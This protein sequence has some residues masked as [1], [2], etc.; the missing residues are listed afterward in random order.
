VL[1]NGECFG[2]TVESEKTRLDAIAAQSTFDPNKYN[3]A[4]RGDL[5]CTVSTTVDTFALDTAVSSTSSSDGNVLVVDIGFTDSNQ[6]KAQKL[7]G[8]SDTTTFLAVASSA[9][10]D[11]NG[12]N[13]DVLDHL[14]VSCPDPCFG[15]CTCDLEVMAVTAGGDFT[16]DGTRPQLDSFNVNMDAAGL[17]TM[18][19]TE[20]VDVDSIYAGQFSLQWKINDA[21]ESVALTGSSVAAK[22]DLCYNPACSSTQDVLGETKCG[23]AHG[24]KWDSTAGVC[25]NTHC[26]L[27][28]D[29][30]PTASVLNAIKLKRGLAIT[31]ET[32]YMAI[33]NTPNAAI[34][35]MA[36]LPADAIATGAAQIAK[37]FEDDETDPTL[38][39]YVLDM[40]NFKLTLSFSEVVDA[41]SVTE[42]EIVLEGADANEP[43]VKLSGSTSKSTTDGEEIDIIITLGD[44]NK[45]KKIKTLATSPGSTFLTFNDE[46]VVDAATVPNKVEAVSRMPC[47][48]LNYKPDTVS[49]VIENFD[50]NMATGVLTLSF[51]ETVLRDRIQVNELRIQ[52]SATAPGQTRPLL[53]LADVQ[54]D[55]SHIITVTLDDADLN[56]IKRLDQTCTVDGGDCF[57]VSTI[58]AAK[59]M[60]DVNQVDTVVLAVSSSGYAE[61]TIDPQFLSFDLD[62]HNGLLTIVFD[63]TVDAAEL[64]VDAIELHTDKT[65]P[66]VQSVTLTKLSALAPGGSA[67][68]SADS[69]TIIITLGDDD[70]DELKKDTSLAVATASSVFLTATDET[71]K[72]MN[73]QSLVGV[74]NTPCRTGGFT[75]DLVRPTLEGFEMD[76]N[77]R[78]ITLTFSETMKATDLVA[79]EFVLQNAAQ[80]S[81]DNS[82]RMIASGVK[83][84][85]D[86]PVL[87]FV[88]SE[89]DA[90]FL[91]IKT[92]LCTHATTV[93]SVTT[94]DCY[95]RLTENAAKDMDGNK[96]FAKLD[97]AAIPLLSN[98]FVAD[99]QSPVL[100]G[101]DWEMPT[102][103]PPIKLTLTFS[104]T[105]LLSS[106]SVNFIFIRDGQGT[107]VQ[108]STA[109]ASQQ[110]LNPRILELTVHV[111]DLASV[112]EA[113]GVGS[114]PALTWLSIA[115]GAITD[116]ANKPVQ[117][118]FAS[119]PLQVNDG[120]HSVDVT[121]PKVTKF[122]LDLDTGYLTVYY[123]DASSIDA[124][125][126]DPSKFTITS[127]RTN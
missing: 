7:I 104:E 126:V 114:T 122:D 123:E 10:Q 4:F 115:P 98:G 93:N 76:M 101:F 105:V 68:S 44:M 25:G 99:N 102:G 16:Q 46:L 39:S 8:V 70:L 34:K 48:T 81:G 65:Q 71:I 72:D 79:T 106:L 124:S 33:S 3:D 60:T 37:S 32:S 45:I 100:Q 6:L 95:I 82:L 89:V 51:S 74:A 85:T 14:T 47:P 77:S 87:S 86:G 75:P 50:L 67:S 5:T 57:L 26:G 127:E 17:I 78:T 27:V 53:A 52:N 80:S 21:T 49:P 69:T 92:G 54:A 84:Q 110:P 36:G 90:D 22:E 42:T 29:F 107:A 58:N 111:D 120:G 15:T 35:D 66:N 125:T 12:N 24:C 61:D 108:L 119:N 59:D 2:A 55:D 13:V 117:E 18:T 118:I 20:T 43:T 113:G 40:D 112:R 1:E 88:F 38:I 23:Q 94:T 9:V 64:N 116:H 62:M 121:P 11:M 91:K 63:E 30:T 31:K 109:V 83:S 103:K 96:V 19:F 28:V 56:E 73:G 41:V 97:G